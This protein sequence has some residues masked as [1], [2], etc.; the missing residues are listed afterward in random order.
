MIRQSLLCSLGAKRY[1][2][3]NGENLN[4]ARSKNCKHSRARCLNIFI[5]IIRRQIK[6]GHFAKIIKLPL[7]LRAHNKL[8]DI[9]FFICGPC[10]LKYERSRRIEHFALLSYH[11]L[12]FSPLCSIQYLH[13]LSFIFSSK[14]KDKTKTLF[15]VGWSRLKF[16][17]ILFSSMHMWFDAIVA[18]TWRLLKIEGREQESVEEISEKEF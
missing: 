4:I 5:K 9:S 13:I 10:P 7:R 14:F 18:E 16:I 12:H 2:S 17:S 8:S 1:F 11:S 3:V 6:L 15:A